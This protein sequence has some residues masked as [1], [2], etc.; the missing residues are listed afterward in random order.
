MIEK[1]IL[2]EL[3]AHFIGDYYLQTGKIA[4][5][6]VSSYYYT[7]IHSLLYAVP[8]Y[9]V[10]YF[11]AGQDRRLLVYITMVVGSHWLIDTGKVYITTHR[12]K[13]KTGCL[14]CLSDGRKLYVIDQLMH[15]AV[16]IIMAHGMKKGMSGALPQLW[17]GISV[18]KLKLLFF[19]VMFLQPWYVSGKILWQNNSKISNALDFQ[20][21]DQKVMCALWALLI[22]LV[23]LWGNFL[24]LSLSVA[25]LWKSGTKGPKTDKT[26]SF[27]MTG[28]AASLIKWCFIIW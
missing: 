27:A 25:I 5:G 15:F 1:L 24:I 19:A 23:P 20:D 10:W 6:K 11:P 14:H 13:L 8:H 18:E 12:E 22:A 7:G 9:M 2:L 3:I 4:A 26:K 16:M 28:V 17:K 21:L